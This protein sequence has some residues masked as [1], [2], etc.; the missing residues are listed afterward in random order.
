[1]FNYDGEIGSG[2]HSVKS[3]FRSLKERASFLKKRS[4][5]L[6]LLT[7]GGTLQAPV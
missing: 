7:V 6:L 4:K 5:K 2:Y 3:Q 1:M